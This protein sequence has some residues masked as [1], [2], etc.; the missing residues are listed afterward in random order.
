LQ[1]QT[2]PLLLLLPLLLHPA[3]HLTT[4]L[5]QEGS[6]ALHC[7]PALLHLL[8]LVLAE[9]QQQMQQQSSQLPDRVQTYCCRSCW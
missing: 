4:A 6:S 1:D 9:A 8:L 5:P 2:P 7:W 3:L